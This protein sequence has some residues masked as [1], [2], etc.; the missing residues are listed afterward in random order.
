[1]RLG[2]RTGHWRRLTLAAAAALVAALATGTTHTSGA[3]PDA[4]SAAP[5][6]LDPE[7]AT[8]ATLDAM[9]ASHAISSV[10]LTK[11]YLNRIYTL[12]SHAPALNAVRAINPDAVREAAA[13]DQ[14]LQ[15]GKAH[16]PLLGIPVIVKDNI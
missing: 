2:R 8:V 1:M 15:S 7:T 14:I 11:A 16:G 5:P 12:N 10:E 6:A 13:A 3:T 9:L 4:P